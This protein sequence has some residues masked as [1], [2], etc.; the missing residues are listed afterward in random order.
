MANNESPENAS[1]T[2]GS[3]TKRSA[4]IGSRTIRHAS[5]NKLRAIAAAAP[6]SLL[7]SPSVLRLLMIRSPIRTTHAWPRADAHGVHRDSKTVCRNPIQPADRVFQHLGDHIEHESDV[8]LV[9]F[10]NGHLVE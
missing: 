9:A 7:T 4:K 6:S 8:G 1:R 2:I 10:Q 5:N 3:K